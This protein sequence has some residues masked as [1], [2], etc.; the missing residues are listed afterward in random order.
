M[1]NLKQVICV[2]VLMMCSAT[3]PAQNLFD[4]LKAAENPP[5][6]ELVK[7]SVDVYAFADK[8]PS[9]PGG[10][11]ALMKQINDKSQCIPKELINGLDEK[12]SRVVVGFVIEKD[13]SCSNF[14]VVKGITPPLDNASLDAVKRVKMKKW[15]PA[16]VDGNP[17]RYAMAVAVNF[18]YATPKKYF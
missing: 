13:G 4:L 3:A 9:Y 5:K 17:V 8:R 1:K 12:G 15:K 11:A 16:E 10:M 7:D 14:K 18:K 6:P 2:G